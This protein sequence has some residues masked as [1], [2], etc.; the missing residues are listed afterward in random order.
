MAALRLFVAVPVAPAL[1]DGIAELLAKMAKYRG[2]RW[3]SKAQLHITLRFIGDF[4]EKLLPKLEQGLRESALSS[5]PFEAEIG[6]LGAFPRLERPRVLFIPVLKGM[7]EFGSLEKKLS[8]LLGSFGVE[9]DDKEYYPHLTLGRVREKE[10]PEAAVKALKGTCPAHWE[11][12]K[13]DRF[14]LF[15]SQLASGGSIYTSL[16]DYGFG[17]E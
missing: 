9:P 14:I 3:V 15:K 2:V 1:A 13:A 7:E 6:G 16:G 10:D 4:E 8:V 12:W 11:S 5:A 17:K